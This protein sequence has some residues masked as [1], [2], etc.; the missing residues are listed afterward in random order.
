[1]S[2]TTTRNYSSE[3]LTRTKVPGIYRRASGTSYVVAYRD[4]RGKQRR[5]TART[6]VEA[7]RLKAAVATDLARGEHREVSRTPF[8]DYAENWI[9]SYA[10]RTA[11]GLRDETRADYEK[12]L[13]R[14]AIPFF[15]RMAVSAITPTDLDKLAES[16]ARSGVSAG[17]VRLQL[18]PVKALFADALQRGDIRIN[19]CA[20]WRTRHT[21]KQ[22]L[23]DGTEAEVVKALT[24]EELAR[25][26]DEV[27]EAWRLFVR[28]LAT[29]GMRIGEAV[30]L[31][32]KDIDLGGQ[33]LHVQRRFYRGSVGAP[34][35]KYGRRRVRLSSGIARDLWKLQAT[36][37]PAG[38]DLVFTA[39]GGT[40]LCQSNFARRV[41]KPAARRAGVPW[42]SLHTLRHTC[43]TRL[44]RNGWNAVQV[45]RTLGHHTP[46]F[47]LDTYVHLL[48]G[49]LPEPD[50]LDDLPSGNSPVTAQSETPRD[51]AA[52]DQPETRLAPTDDLVAARTG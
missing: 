30:E 25:L 26:L 52:T 29:T 42:A 50:F 18:A 47:T 10:G 5:R 16:I 19:P 35:S 41:F 51:A 13:Q 14:W 8:N 34:K 7:K 4:E 17:T 2:S 22:P 39:E 36:T 15:G 1:M 46:S 48:P 49:D 11:R 20:G 38:D 45:Q 44:L 40:R 3:K 6:M 43:A 9:A 21:Q 27:P 31:R 37:H 12:A 24:D 23:E 32:W 33:W 28:C